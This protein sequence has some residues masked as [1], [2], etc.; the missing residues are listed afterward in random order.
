[1]W[2][3]LLFVLPGLIGEGY[4]LYKKTLR[5]P[6]ERSVAMQ[7]LLPRLVRSPGSLE[8]LCRHR[9]ASQG[10]FYVCGCF[11]REG[12][13]LRE[14]VTYYLRL[15]FDRIILFDTNKG[16]TDLEFIRD[17]SCSCV[18]FINKRDIS[19]SIRLQSRFY[20]DVYTALRPIDW[21]LFV[22]IDEFLF[23]KQV[24]LD[25]YLKRAEEAKCDIVKINWMCHGNNGQLHWQPGGVLERFPNPVLP[26]DF[27]IHNYVWNSLVK[28]IARG[29]LRARFKDV[30]TLYG[31]HLQYCSANFS[32]TSSDQ[33][34]LP[35]NFD[36][37]F[38]KHF[39]TRSQE[40][41]EEKVF[42]RWNGARREGGF[43]DWRYY[44][45]MNQDPPNI[46]YVYL[47]PECRGRRGPCVRKYMNTSHGITL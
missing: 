34:S 3:H 4:S 14:W 1:M 45:R 2:W 10:L 12:Y 40:E 23:L 33:F 35:L 32:R 11:A 18:K 31:K 30:H 28:T 42:G 21:C 9:P 38:I 17:V 8:G 6:R 16:D 19:F 5:L 43:Y 29:G 7:L 44:D 25:A 24:R 41:Y 13:Y 27:Q 26:L 20:T 47:G 15:G 36:V 46:P 37:A 22:D 39:F